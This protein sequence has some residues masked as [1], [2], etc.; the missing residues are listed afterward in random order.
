MITEW[1]EGSKICSELL[2]SEDSAKQFAN[3]LVE[4]SSYYNFDGWLL[5]IE[6]ALT[7]LIVFFLFN[8]QNILIFI[9]IYFQLQKL[10]ET[11]SMVKFTEYL[12]KRQHQMLP[13]SEVIWYDSVTTKGELIWQNE[14]NTLNLLVSNVKTLKTMFSRPFKFSDLSFKHVMAF[15][16]ITH[17]MKATW[18]FPGSV[19]WT[20]T[21]ACKMST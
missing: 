16:S 5:N 7:V 17:G 9:Q 21:D 4:L 8:F 12:T 2:K 19:A 3:K 15:F 13:F 18:T 10:Q 20:C 11:E 6:N 14:L 1:N